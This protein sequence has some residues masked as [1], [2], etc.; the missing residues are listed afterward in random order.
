MNKKRDKEELDRIIAT[1]NALFNDIEDMPI[2]EIRRSLA[3]AGL[4]RSALR[5]RLHSRAKEIARAARAEGRA[6]SPGLVNLI[7][8][9]GDAK[10]LSSDPKRAF[11]KAK[12]YMSNLFRSDVS[13]TA[14]QIVGAFRGEGDL[15]DRDKQTIVEIDAELRER[16]ESEGLDESSKE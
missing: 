5:E 13:G 2:D 16:A 4:D 6:A 11:D 10:T 8:Q 3:D 12:R 9:T 7:D 15:S 14:P 1:Y